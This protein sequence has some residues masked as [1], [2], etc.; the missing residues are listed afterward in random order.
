[1]H[2]LGKTEYREA[3]QGIVDA[4]Q[5]RGEAQEPGTV[6]MHNSAWNYLVE[7]AHAEMK[8]HAEQGPYAIV[9]RLVKDSKVK[10]FIKEGKL[11]NEFLEEQIIQAVSEAAA[12]YGEELGKNK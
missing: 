4:I 5:E 1:M 9:E 6:L 2:A 8:K 10:Q 11:K 7:K 3:K 12:R